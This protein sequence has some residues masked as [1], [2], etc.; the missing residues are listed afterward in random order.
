MCLEPS[1]QLLEIYI[2]NSLLTVTSPSISIQVQLGGG[3]G[4]VPGGG[5]QSQ[6]TP[7]SFTVQWGS[8]SQLHLPPSLS[9]GVGGGGG[10][11]PGISVLQSQ[12]TRCK[13]LLSL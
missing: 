11:V 4:V 3:R 5:L 10:A 8:Y 1:L 7:P 6:F 12:V 9:A 13:V 2:Y